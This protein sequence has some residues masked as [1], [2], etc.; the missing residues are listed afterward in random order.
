VISD[1]GY[2]VV[3]ADVIRAIVRLQG[4]R[5]KVV[6]VDA[7]DLKRFRR[8]G[9]T[10]V[11]PNHRQALALLGSTSAREA[12]DR[13]ETIEA[14]GERLLRETG[15]RIVAVTLDDEGALVIER[16]RPSYRTYANPVRASL[17]CGAGDTFTAALT[18]GLAAGSSTPA[19]AE[20]ASA[21]AEIVV[22]R[23][24]T[25][26]CSSADLIERM[27]GPAKVAADATEIASWTQTQRQAGRRIVLTSGCFDLL[28]R[29]H[30]TYLSRAK[31]FGDVLIVGVN[32]DGTVASLKGPDR[33]VNPLGDRMEV[34]A[35]LSCVDRVCAFDEPTPEAL[36]RAIRPDVFVKGGDYVAEMLPEASAV[37]EHGG[38]VRIVP[39]FEDRSTSR[40]IET[41]RSSRDRSEAAAAVRAS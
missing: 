22:A 19:A 12:E 34:L 6:V 28:H 24:G 29:G 23:E 11:K 8:L 36:V 17:T 5:P 27:S 20:L 9:P 21:A 31:S 2:G 13:A 38:Q 10:A 14:N 18:I 30:V 35:A 32:T 16:D 33:P 7:K 3:T 25:A 1:Y 15:A 41:I 37:R 26:E 40:L 39:Y 4:D